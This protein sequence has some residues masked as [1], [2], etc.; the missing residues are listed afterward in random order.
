MVFRVYLG[1]DGKFLP[2]E[3]VGE[4]HCSVQDACDS[5]QNIGVYKNLGEKLLIRLFYGH[6]KTSVAFSL[7]IMLSS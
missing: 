6:N 2:E 3:L 4:V 1:K 5:R 7:S